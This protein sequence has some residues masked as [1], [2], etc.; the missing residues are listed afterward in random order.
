MPSQRLSSSSS[1]SI[2]I[3][4]ALV[5]LVFATVAMPLAQGQTF[6]VLHKFIGPPDGGFPQSD[7]A[8]RQGRIELRATPEEER[9]RNAGREP[10]RGS[11]RQGGAGGRARS[12]LRTI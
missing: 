5:V 11:E 2:S 4:T 8:S 12:A 3:L 7:I 6:I 9:Y 10:T 1:H